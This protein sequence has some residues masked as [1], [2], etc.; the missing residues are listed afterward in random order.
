[1]ALA[2]FQVY[3]KEDA[4]GCEGMALYELTRPCAPGCE[5]LHS[6]PDERWREGSRKLPP[7]TEF[8]YLSQPFHSGGQR[9]YKDAT[10][11]EIAEDRANVWA[12]NGNRERPSLTPSFV[13]T[14]HSHP[15]NLYPDYPRVHTYLTDG[16]LVNCGDS[17][18]TFIQ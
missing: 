12:W 5:A 18:A 1:M 16:V 4:R 11:E 7:H 6:P 10:P 13:F 2:A 17:D 14:G 3:E 9:K 15:K 8:R